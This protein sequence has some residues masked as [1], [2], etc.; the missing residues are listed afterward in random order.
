MSVTGTP[1]PESPTALDLV[2]KQVVERSGRYDLVDML[3]DGSPDY[4]GDNGVDA[5]ILNG[6]RE[7]CRRLPRTFGSRYVSSSVAIGTQSVSLTNM[8]RIDRVYWKDTDGLRTALE[9]KTPE[10][11]ETEYPSVSD[12]IWT[13]TAPSAATEDLGTPVYWFYLPGSK[14]RI[15]IAPYPEEA[16]TLLAYG[17]WLPSDADVHDETNYIVTTMPELLIRA[18]L[19]ALLQDADRISSFELELR[20][21]RVDEVRQELDEQKVDGKLSIGG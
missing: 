11:I 21:Y 2:R 9:L 1:V 17:E 12:V 10:W 8:K 15:G 7:I 3:N 14:N 4:T 20:Q 6:M 18:A 13:G 5:F 19:V 16:G